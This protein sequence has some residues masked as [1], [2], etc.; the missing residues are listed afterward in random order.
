M[1]ITTLFHPH[2]ILDLV[3][4]AKWR[5][6]HIG[7]R[8]FVHTY[9]QKFDAREDDGDFQRRR[10]MAYCPAFAKEGIIEIKN[11]IYQR[12]NE[13]SRK[14]GSPSYR[15]AID[16]VN[17]GVDLE[18]SNMNSFIGQKILPEMMV[19]G[20]VGVFVDM[21]R[22]EPVSTLAHFQ[23]AP[24]PYLYQY[25][26]ED[27]V[28]WSWVCKENELYFTHL[29]LRER[30]FV[31]DE[32]SGL[33]KGEEEVYRFLRLTDTGVLVQFWKRNPK[34]QNKNDLDILLEEFTLDLPMIP[35]VLFSIGN[36]LLRDVADYQIGLLNL[37]S[38]DLNY[39]LKSNFPFYTEQYDQKT[40]DLYKNL[41]PLTNVTVG[42]DGREITTERDGRQKNISGQNDAKEVSTG[43]RHGRRYPIGAERPGF[44]HPSS[45]PLKASMDKQLQMREEIR[46]LLNLSVS[47]VSPTRASA[48]SK[49]VDQVGLESGLASI[50]LELQGGERQ[51]ARI[52]EAYQNNTSY[53]HIVYPTTY[54]LKS[55]EQ[56][57]T[58]AEKQKELKVAVPSKTFQ[59]WM[60]VQIADTLF[61]GKVPSEELENV[62]REIIEANF[63]TSDPQ[64][65]QIDMNLGL[66][67]AE[68]A[69]N[70]RGYDGAK[71]VPQAQKEHAERLAIISI[72]QSKGGGA[73]AARGV[74]DD[75]G[76]T[77]AKDEKTLSQKTPD[78]QA[79]PADKKVRG[80][81]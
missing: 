30:R 32:F 6:T 65:I 57:M 43:V 8:Q 48:E 76:D 74:T 17:G 75:P 80:N 73:G 72:A 24:R 54:S 68:T 67:T 69:S 19:M 41:G 18:G 1:Q 52:W 63:I 34:P 33:P 81:A 45:E 29:L 64:E 9:L 70:A 71:E 62:H 12:M 7:G 10:E 3:E 23:K 25:V 40:E 2:Y 47:N 78:L 22:F 27:I 26:A 35:F 20:K 31:F 5:L 13:I 79:N 39:A 55:D 44:I 46:Q 14:N 77:S 36:S 56:R 11:G 21:P 42:L 15:E 49:R 38:S 60:A 4:Y 37:A 53:S 28:N 51:L 66:V 59:K 61:E 58:E 16:G 50:G